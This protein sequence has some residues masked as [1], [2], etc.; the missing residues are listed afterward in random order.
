M[1]WTSYFDLMRVISLVWVKNMH[2]HTDGLD[3]FP[4]EFNSSKINELIQRCCIDG[5]S[6]TNLI[7]DYN[8][9]CR[10][11][12]LLLA[13]NGLETN[14]SNKDCSQKLMLKIVA[15]PVTNPD[16]TILIQENTCPGQDDPHSNKEIV[17]RFI[18]SVESHLSMKSI[19]DL[20]LKD[21]L[22][23]V[24]LLHC[25]NSSTTDGHVGPLLASH[26]SEF[27][28]LTIVN[29]LVENHLINISVFSD[30]SAF[31]VENNRVTE[32]DTFGITWKILLENFEHSV[33]QVNELI[34]HSTWPT[35]WHSDIK[36][37]WL[38]LAVL[39]CCNYLL[40]LA[41][42]RGFQIE[43]TK[44]LEHKLLN[45]LHFHPISKCFHVFEEAA[46][47]ASDTVIKNATH[48]DDA[49]EFMIMNILQQL[50][51]QANP[52]N[53]KNRPSN[54]LNSQLSHI[55]H[56]NFLKVGDASF[57]I[58]PYAYDR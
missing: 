15:E 35:R 30:I 1:T 21:V 42:E 33:F 14:F 11:T 32:F 28:A 16:K 3:S 13:L 58:V 38:E 5:N 44:G 50:E 8:L 31:Q 39:E 25:V 52:L 9:D 17:S 49:G 12:E 53:E 54:C 29:H 51:M 45:F 22:Y 7:H 23:L 26:I 27:E 55:F 41:D 20:C 24:T 10:P 47:E 43:I 4:P 40:N 57:L 37:L 46:R 6:V 48:K 36:S 18:L 34:K 2:S 19:E 56:H